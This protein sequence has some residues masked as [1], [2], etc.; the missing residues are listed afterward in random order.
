[1]KAE[2][3]RSFGSRAAFVMAD[4]RGAWTSHGEGDEATVRGEYQLSNRREKINGLMA[5]RKGKIIA[6]ESTSTSLGVGHASLVGPNAME[7]AK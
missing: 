2:R 3:E 5:T 7:H 1:L 4:G 6:L